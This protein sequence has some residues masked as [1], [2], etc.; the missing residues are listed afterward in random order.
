MEKILEH[1][2]EIMI[3]LGTSVFIFYIQPILEYLGVFFIKVCV[4]ASDKY[5]K[6]YYSAIAQ[7]DTAT[8]SEFNG[9]ILIYIFTIIC[10]TFIYYFIITKDDLRSKAD[11]I[12]RTIIVQKEELEAI[13]NKD[14][15]RK[16][17]SIEEL[18]A[19]KESQLIDLTKIEQRALKLKERLYKGDNYIIFTTI[20]TITLALIIYTSYAKTVSVSKQNLVFKNDL[21]KISPFVQDSTIKILQSDWARI[22]NVNDLERIKVKVDSIKQKNNIK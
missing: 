21:I 11:E 2:K 20:L 13:E 6:S 15:D 4:Q 7:N 3:S 10:I 16:E 17:Y 5:S 12:L 19:K 9:L 22:K 8:F 1:K 18:F 14:T